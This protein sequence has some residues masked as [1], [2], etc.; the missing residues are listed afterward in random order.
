MVRSIRACFIVVLLL[1]CPRRREWRHGDAPVLRYCAAM[2]A[3]TGCRSIIASQA[4][5]MWSEMA[6]P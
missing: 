4:V 1:A 5:E 3:E 2:P 6:W